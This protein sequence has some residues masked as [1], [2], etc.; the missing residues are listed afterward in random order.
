M[1]KDLKI[2]GFTLV[3]MALYVG[4]CSIVLFSLSTLFGIIVSS[5]AKNQII[6]EVNQ[7]GSF[8]VTTIASLVRNG[9]T[10]V[11]PGSGVSSSTLTITSTDG[12]VNPALVYASGTTLFIKEGALLPVALT[13][14]RVRITNLIF[15]NISSS[16]TDKIIRTTFTLDGGSNSLRQEFLYNK[17]F[18][19]S[20][21]LRQ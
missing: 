17:T 18:I 13:N 8:V 16:T 20:A 1:N 14:R 2:R 19:G 15:E 10:I 12:A 7:Q 4:V 9:S 5:R 3:E 6:T 21:T 11:T